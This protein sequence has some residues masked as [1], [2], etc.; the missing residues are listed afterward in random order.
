MQSEVNSETINVCYWYVHRKYLVE[1]PE[2][3]KIFLA[4]KARVTDVLCSWEINSQITKLRVCNHF[5]PHS[6][7]VILPSPEQPG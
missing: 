5:G 3:H 7:L 4:R 2:I 6:M 1:A